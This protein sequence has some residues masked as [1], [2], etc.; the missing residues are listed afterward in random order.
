MTKLGIIGAMQVE[1]E[2]LLGRMENKTEK[3]IAGSTFYEGTLEGLPAVV[4]QCGVGKVNAAICAQILCD[5][6]GVTHLVNTGIAGSLCAELDIGDLVVSR[7][8]MYHDFDCNAFGYPSGKVPGMDVIAFPADETMMDYAFSAAE[9]VNPGHTKVGRIA[10][11]D[12]FVAEKALKER[13]IALTHG[14]C[15]EMEGAAIAQTAYRNGI[16]FVILRAISDKADDSAEMDYP[17]FERIA[18]HRCAEV[19]CKLAKMLNE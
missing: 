7:D 2:I 10:S 18:A 19:T 4:V 13:I 5:C 14:L 6:F 8:A 17:T 16:P 9:S 15:T 1:V 12:Q 11:G 3:N